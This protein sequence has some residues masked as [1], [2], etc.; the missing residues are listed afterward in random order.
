MNT[1]PE[2]EKDGI[3]GIVAISI[4]RYEE[5]MDCETRVATAL[6]FYDKRMFANLDDIIIILGGNAKEEK[7]DE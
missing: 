1:Y 6:E 5:L 3:N 4:E 2:I 7:K